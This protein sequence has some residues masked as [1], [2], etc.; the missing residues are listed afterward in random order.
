MRTMTAAVAAADP[1]LARVIARSAAC[2]IRPL[3]PG[4]ASE[5]AFFGALARSIL[6]QQLA[7]KAA[8]AIHG[9]FLALF[10]GPPTPAAVLAVPEEN[11]R[12]VG[13]STNKARSITDLA[14]K[15]AEGDVPLDGVE[16]LAD[17]DVV[18]S[19][20]RVRG[21]G[22][23]TVEMFLMFQL[24]RLDVWPVDD[25]G[26]R[27]GFAA[28]RGLPELPSPKDLVALGDVFRPYRSV[29][30]WYCWRATEVEPVLPG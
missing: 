6:F 19:L 13:L 17:D 2:T 1:G 10:D 18:A 29:A 27:K 15:V 30:A 20:T 22:R 11:L 4:D 25:Y 3:R 21:I 14:R 28:A 16:R 8:A 9:R 26:I 12:A 7:G 24:G 5:T 23:W